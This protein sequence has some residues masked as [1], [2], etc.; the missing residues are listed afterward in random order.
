MKKV[1][2]IVAM[3]VFVAGLAM[4][5]TPPAKKTEKA[6]PKKEAK[7]DTTKKA[8]HAKHMGKKGEKKAEVK[9]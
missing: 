1:L 4:A 5:Q 7:A 8:A 3:F 6:E 9:K 2:S